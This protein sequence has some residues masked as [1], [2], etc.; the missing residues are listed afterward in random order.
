MKKFIALLLAALLTCALATTALAETTLA[1][2]GHTCQYD[3]KNTGRDVYRSVDGSNHKLFR[4][5]HLICTICGSIAKTV[6]AEIEGERPKPH[7]TNGKYVYDFHVAGKTL[8][9]FM[10]KCNVCL[11][12]CYPVTVSC[13]GVDGFHVSHP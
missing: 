4:E 11:A 12:Y 2:T 10:E 3:L 6:Y 5:Q 13:A 1:V 7:S 8:H 9:T